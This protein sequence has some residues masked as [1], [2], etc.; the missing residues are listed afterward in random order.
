MSYFYYIKNLQN[1][2]VLSAGSGSP[3]PGKPLYLEP[4]IRPRVNYQLWHIDNPASSYIKLVGSDLVLRK[5]TSGPPGA[6]WVRLAAPD[7]SPAQFWS[8]NHDVSRITNVGSGLML[9]FT[10]ILYNFKIV[11]CSQPIDSEDSAPNG[12]ATQN[13]VTAGVNAFAWQ[14]QIAGDNDPE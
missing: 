11:T 7:N 10:N 14:L 13:V 4:L 6:Y 3:E 1:G 8:Y 5:E 12:E 9:N 2:D